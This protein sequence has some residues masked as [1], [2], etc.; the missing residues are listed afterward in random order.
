MAE[1]EK[2]GRTQNKLAEIV[3]CVV[4]CALC[5]VVC[6]VCRGVVWCGVVVCGGVLWCGAVWFTVW[7]AVTACDGARPNASTVDGAVLAEARHNKGGIV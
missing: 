3:L 4:R 2:I 5:V 6:V 1:L 7:S